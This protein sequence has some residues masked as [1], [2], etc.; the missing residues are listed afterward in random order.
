[1]D[2]MK[3][4]EFRNTLERLHGEIKKTHVD[5]EDLWQCL[6]Q[7]QDHIEEIWSEPD[8]VTEHH[9]LSLIKKLRKIVDDFEI[10]HP[11][12]T[13]TLG[14]IVDSLSRMGF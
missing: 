6:L 2:S 9:R 5:D 1:M 11:E 10:S 4:Q 7:I 12:L 13:S 14:E 3:K 8:T